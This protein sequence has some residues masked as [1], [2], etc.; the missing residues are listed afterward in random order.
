MIWRDPLV[1]E[2]KIPPELLSKETNTLWFKLGSARYQLL[3]KQYEFLQATE[4]FISFIGGYGSGKTRVGSIRAARHSM[5]P[6]NRGI[7]GRLARTDLEDTSQRDL[8]DFLREAELLKEAPNARNNRALVHCIDPVTGENLGG[9][10]EIAFQ[11]LDDP[12]H[13]RGRHIGWWWIDEGSEV[14]STASQNLTGRLRLPVAKG[15]YTGF[16]TGNPEGHNWIYDFWFNKELLEVMTCG[17]KPG[18]HVSGRCPDYDDAKCN[19]RLRKKRRAIHCTSFENYFLP[20]ETLD[21]QIYSF[22]EA[23]RQRYL[24][25]S[26][27]VFEGQLF[28]EFDPLIHCV[29]I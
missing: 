8:L 26:F 4:E 28:P 15:T 2:I 20:V 7:V 21:A 13:L 9:E 6:G 23:D 3:P 5:I 19:A 24:E 17:G 12:E 18:T 10:A 25:A 29:A 11:H 16:T 22:S 14:K 27:S 1:P